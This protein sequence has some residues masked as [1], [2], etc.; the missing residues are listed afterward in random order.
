MVKLTGGTE[1]N[2]H[3]NERIKLRGPSSDP[4][5]GHS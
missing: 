5:Q 4:L 1:E 2:H 3:H